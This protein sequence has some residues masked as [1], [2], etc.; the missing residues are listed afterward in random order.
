MDNVRPIDPK[1]GKGP[2]KAAK[3]RVGDH[4]RRR[5][6]IAVVVAAVLIV[7]A[8]SGRILGLYVDWLWFGEVGFTPVFW[9]RFWWHVVVAVIAFAVFFVIVWPN[10]ELARRL[11]PSYRVT[12]SGDL[13]E[14]R[15]DRVKRW[16]GWGGLVVCV[17]VAVVAASSL[18]SDWQTFLLYLKQVPFGQTDPIFGRDVSFYVFSLPMWQAVQGFVFAALVVGARPHRRHAPHHGRHR[19]HRQARARRPA[20]AQGAA[21]HRPAQPLRR[22]AHAHADPADR[23]QARRARRGAP[24]GH[25]RGHLRRHRRRPA[26]PRLEAPVL[27]GRRRVRRR[28]HGRAH[29]PAAHV[30]GSWPSPSPSPPCSS[31][32][33][34]GAASGGRWPSASGW[35][36]SSSCGASC[37]P[38]TSRSS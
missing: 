33:C 36:R 28:L 38:S 14:P 37:R 29:P 18:S 24:L 23:P 32:T 7:L 11:A 35:S 13:L 5:I 15:S 20:G 27:D 9:T 34:G 19:L 30:R 3:P 10:V 8:L 17:L 31:G 4:R 1:R 2:K 6:V 12:S 26:L 22:R 21:L 16:V 25:P